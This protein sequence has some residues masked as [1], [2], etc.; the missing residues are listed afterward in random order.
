[1]VGRGSGIRGAAGP[2]GV[3]VGVVVWVGSVGVGVGLAMRC[4]VR[5]ADADLTERFSGI[6][7]I[8]VAV[9]S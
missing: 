2:D 1:M 9:V 7:S 5:S 8:G 4:C 3:G 6:R